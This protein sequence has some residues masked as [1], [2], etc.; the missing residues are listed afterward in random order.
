MSA[1]EIRDRVQHAVVQERWKRRLPALPTVAPNSG[2]RS[3][4]ALPGTARPSQDASDAVIA[5]A[6]GL[7][8]G[9]WTMLGHPRTDVTA[10]VDYYLDI[11]T[12]RRAPADDAAFSIDHRDE[13]AVGNIKFVWELAR[14]QHLTVLAAAYHLTADERYAT[15]I[16]DELRRYWSATP[17]VRGIHWTSGIEIGLRLMSWVWIRRLLDGWSGAGDLFEDNP[18]FVEHLAR[19]HQWI[20]AFASPGSSANNHLIAEAAGHYSAAVAFPLFEASPRWQREAAET[21]VE[22]LTA[23]TFPDGLN[24]ELASDYHGFVLE[25]ALTP[26]LEAMFSGLPDL[27]ALGDPLRAAFDALESVVDVGGRPHRQGDADDAHGLLVDPPSYDRW[28]SLRATGAILFSDSAGLIPD[29][30]RSGLVAAIVAAHP[31]PH[32]TSATVTRHSHFA[33]AGLTILR[34][35][36]P[37]AEEIWC[38]VDHGQL[39]YLSTAAHGHADALSV[40]VRFGGVEILADP[41]TYCYHGEREWRDYFRST[42]AHNTVQIG[43]GDQS[44]IGGPF[45]W[46][47]HAE[48]KLVGVDGLDSGIEATVTAEHDGYDTIDAHHRRRITLDRV[49]RQLVIADQLTLG[50]S[51][52][53]HLRFHLGPEIDCDLT[54]QDLTLRWT[55]PQGTPQSARLTLPAEFAWRIV[56][57]QE[58]PPMGWYSP[59]FGHKVPTFSVVGSANVAGELSV[60]STLQFDQVRGANDDTA[61]ERGPASQAR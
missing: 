5:A 9:H 28:A 29:D 61:P 11:K 33:D 47:R 59:H 12:G 39:G 30:V 54:D 6:E 1:V 22:Q 60:E 42:A 53:V 36:E 57:G 2:R 10:D 48:A 44:D 31:R 32:P 8:D 43:P 35:L 45:L 34:D 3:P 7:L 52:D 58:S 51:N 55:A 14:H 56:R 37:T 18:V 17:P 25:L 40:E 41:G 38:M 46:T 24:R 13:Q 23:Q 27:D 50:A 21:L 49:K 19:H 4:V 20:D 15:R 16:D 26:F